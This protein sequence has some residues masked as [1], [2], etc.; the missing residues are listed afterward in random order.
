MTHRDTVADRDSGEYDRVAA[1][2]CDACLDSLNDL[3][4]VH[5]SG[6]DLVVGADDTDHR[7]LHFLVGHA[8]RVE[9]RALGCAGN[10]LGNSVT[11]HKYNFL[12]DNGFPFKREA[13][14]ILH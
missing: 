5:M 11:S 13:Q 14:K 9:E 2:H 3:V 12:S 8:E 6:Y 10:A 7:L 4:Y 1:C